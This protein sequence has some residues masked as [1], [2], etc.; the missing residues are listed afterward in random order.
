MKKLLIILIFATLALSACGGDGGGETTVVA[1]PPPGTELGQMPVIPSP[2][3]EIPDYVTIQ[4][5]QFS[6]SLTSLD[7]TRRN[8]ADEEMYPLRYMLNLTELHLSNS[9]QWASYAQL[10]D[11]SALAGL[12]N[13]T[14][15]YLGG[16]RISD[17]TPLA[18]LTN[19]RVL[20]I[21]GNLIS[22]ITPLSGLTNLIGL[23]LMHNQIDDIQVLANLTN[24]ES[25]TLSSNQISDISP[26]GNLTNLRFL[27]IGHNQISSLAPL[28]G[29]RN[30]DI[31]SAGGNP[32]T[33]L[34]PLADMN[35][36]AMLDLYSAQISDIS[37]LANLQF[38]Q[39]INLSD[40]QI[41]DIHPLT[42]L[43]Q[44]PHINVFLDD[45]PVTD[46]SPLINIDFVGGR[47]VQQ[48]GG[49]DGG[50][51]R[52]TVQIPSH[53]WAQMS[54]C[55]EERYIN[56]IGNLPIPQF[57]DIW[58]DGAMWV[59]S[60]HDNPLQNNPTIFMV[61]FHFDFVMYENVFTTISV[62]AVYNA[63]TDTMLEFDMFTPWAQDEEWGIRIDEENVLA[64]AR[65]CMEAK[66]T[67]IE[68]LEA[69]G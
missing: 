42:S 17:L 59:S 28:T 31:L 49:Q 32:I 10:T 58:V 47:N 39:T 38:L 48:T 20:G 8:L 46:W 40:N 21:G 63:E 56:F 15:L 27:S 9:I 16:N 6:T 2:P 5:E 19:L 64:L 3:L 35:R 14:Y 18:G 22:D 26:L 62:R 68:F 34:T 29:L 24:L 33:D 43:Q 67:A 54:F 7:L 36:L 30:L 65:L 37:A 50:R 57:E 13:L 41:S 44:Y 55:P 12:T 4:G 51:G 61:H 52:V 11:I 45:N 53:N 23:D 25:L 69:R 60:L 66:A 1:S